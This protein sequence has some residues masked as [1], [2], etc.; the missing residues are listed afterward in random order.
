MSL[1]REILD[2]AEDAGIAVGPT[3]TPREALARLQR[4]R[5]MSDAAR[6]ALAR[7]GGALE[8]EGYGPPQGDGATA[9]V[10]NAII[11]DARVIISCLVAS[12]PSDARLKAFLLPASLVTRTKRAVGRW[13]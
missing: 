5:G 12:A 10:R 1:W 6:E 8:L 7:V 2:T 11:V 9:Q 4:A 13:V 3:L